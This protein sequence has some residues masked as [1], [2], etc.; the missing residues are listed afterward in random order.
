V[1]SFCTPASGTAFPVGT[2]T[3]NCSASDNAGNARSC[4]FTIT[5]TP[6]NQPPTITCPQ[7]VTV[8][9]ATGETSAVVTYPPPTVTDNNPGAT[10]ACV[11]PSGSTFAV[12]TTPVTCTATDVGGNQAF[13]T[14]SVMVQGGPPQG[15]VSIPGGKSNVEFPTSPAR[16]KPK[17]GPCS[18]FSITN[19]GQT[20]LIL[21]FESILRTGADVASGRI[22]DPNEGDLYRL[23]RFNSNGTEVDVSLGGRVTIGVGETANF[24]ARFVPVLPRIATGSTGLAA[25]F[26]VADVI[27]SKVT[28]RLSN[29]S[30]LILPLLANVTTDF[31]FINPNNPKKAPQATFER[32]GDNYILT[33]SIFDSNQDVKNS[34]VE[35]LDS[36]GSAVATFDVD[37]QQPLRDR[38]LVRG[39][40]FTIEQ[41]FTGASA[42]PQ[43]TS[44]RVTVMDGTS[45]A[46][47][48][49]SISSS[50]TA[51][52]V[53][54]SDASAV[55]ALPPLRIR[56]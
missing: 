45:S 34:H 41:R 40:S 33:Y 6:D 56:K 28:F 27:T 4:T 47:L 22:T 49:A 2:T 32:Q 42:N 53:N 26:V 31:S 18:N 48:T 44:V 36:S 5:V 29:G 10:A 20:P 38:N 17:A 19:T 13:C 43:V 3:V 8:Q 30:S 52:R 55:V 11:P 51:L 14:F 50:G 16:R 54:G 21:T 23:S 37:L 1:R 46:A 15:Q 7:N 12:G 39:Q 24:C 35:L 9:V 25:P